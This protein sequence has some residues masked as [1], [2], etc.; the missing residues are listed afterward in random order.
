MALSNQLLSE[1]AKITN[2][3][4]KEQKNTTAYGEVI[5]VGS[6]S[7]VR[8]DGSELLTPF[9]RTVT[10][11]QGDRVRLKVE[12]HSVTVTG[13][14]SDP[15]YSSSDGE[16]N[17]GKIEEF[18]IIIS[19]KITTDEI[20]AITGYFEQIQAIIANIE[21][22]HAIYAEIE[23]LKATYA[24]IDHLN[25]EDMKVIN[26][27]I[28]KIKSEIIESGHISADDLD[29][30]RAYFNNVQ[31]YNADFVYVSA[32]V[33]KALKAELEELDV[34]HLNARY[35]QI[36]FANIGQAAINKLKANFA[37]ID[38]ANITVAAIDNLTAKMVNIDF[39]TINQATID[40]LKA[41]YAEIDFSNIGIAAI[42]KL[43]TD[44]GIIK[45]LIV[46][47]GKITG[48]LVGVTIKGDLIEGNTIKAD[49]LVVLGED[50]IYYK[51]NID[52]LDHISTTEAAK[53]VLLTEEPDDWEENYKDYYKIVNNEYVHLSD[54]NA[55]IFQTNTFYKLSST[56]QNGLD[57]TNIIAQSVTAD[58]IR[59]SDLVAFGATIGG[60]DIDTHSIHSHLKTS[61]TSNAQGLY[62]NDSGEMAVGDA[63]RFMK[64]FYDQATNTYKLEIKADSIK[65]DSGTKDLK[66]TIN[67]MKSDIQDAQSALN[68]TIKS[69]QTQYAQNQD[70]TT[71]PTSGWS[72]NTPRWQQG[73]YIW[74]KNVVTFNDDTTREDNP[75]CITGN[76]GPQGNP[77]QSGTSSY[78]YVRYSENADGTNFIPNPTST[79]SYIG[80]YTGTLST[81]PSD[82]TAYTWSKYKGEQG[83]QGNPGQQGQP[84]SNGNGINSISYFYAVTT[85][86]VAPAASS[87]TST[88]IPTMSSTNKYLWQK[89][90]IDFTDSGVPD[91]TIVALIGIYGDRGQQGNP[92]QAGT[93]VTITSKSVMYT[94][95]T[96][97]TSIPSSGWQTSVPS[98]TL[99]QF[100][101][102]RT[103]VNYSDGNSTTSYSVAHAGTNGI[104][105]DD[106]L[107]IKTIVEQYYLSTSNT[108][109]SGGS[110][111]TN[112]PQWEENKFI[113]MRM[114]IE[115][116]YD[117]TTVYQTTYT[118]P[119]LAEAL[120]TS[121]EE[122]NN[123]NNK[124]NKWIQSV[125]VYYNT[126]DGLIAPVEGWVTNYPSGMRGKNL[127]IKNIVNYSDG[128][129]SE[130]LPRCVDQFSSPT[131][132]SVTL[133]TQS[134]FPY[135]FQK[136]GDWYINTNQN[137][138]SS[139]CQS[140]FRIYSSTGYAKLKVIYE[141]D[142]EL[143]CDYLTIN[144][145]F[146]S[147]KSSG[148]VYINLSS[149]N[150]D[151]IIKYTKDGSVHTGTDTGR[152]RF[153]IAQ[154]GLNNFYNQYYLSDSG[155]SITGGN[156]VNYVPT[157]N[158][159]TK[160]L[161]K[162]ERMEWD[163]NAITYS[164]AYLINSC[165]IN[166]S[167]TLKEIE[168]SLNTTFGTT[169]NGW[170][171]AFNILTQNFNNL[172]RY[173]RFENGNIVLGEEGNAVT[174]KIENDIIGFY[175]WGQRV[176]YLSDGELQ[177]T[178]A[179]IMTQL[180]LGNFAFVPGKSG[181][182]SFKKVVN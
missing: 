14:L 60:F 65:F 89:Q 178:N 37:D 109:R 164:D 67:D 53:F 86:Q 101:W 91:K 171:M 159:K 102:S 147:G 29:A 125:D 64:Y 110:W 118:D 11:K 76:T 133:I 139:T 154:K 163:T 38:L 155:T 24:T 112:M 16:S 5:R 165:Y 113:W 4:S 168:R 114:K 17:H 33:I 13:N 94:T 85:T 152:V 43:F 87:I 174:L 136:S 134:E 83:P 167:E 82:K 127:W 104:D 166:V 68:L 108:T 146:T 98:V 119:F 95:S 92:G 117:G 100:L 103:I 107:G 7:F 73:Y 32:E 21:E 6:D 56:Y 96:S 141:Q 176:A 145:V 130:M 75:V 169:A 51:L 71:A 28:E 48:E 59:V 8:I 162:R 135:N 12:N 54:A 72:P 93:S 46:E 123:I 22:L 36:D 97:G 172:N 111:S 144:G 88:T 79:T 106:G 116:T 26:A 34:E 126:S 137:Q 180:N 69:I 129:Y 158:D 140:T 150:N 78:T 161:W 177:V 149:G 151:I 148:E 63:N 142:S 31:A 39:A 62:L 153:E 105:G 45:D 99:G 115:W 156:W 20:Y 47:Q 74:A 124:I 128:T 58:K 30:V 157:I 80:I 1:F 131:V 2:D 160:Y 181:N 90:V 41:K 77:G 55:P 42:E 179:K 27:E 18:D 122:I 35:A 173:I 57:G 52:G 19:H 121:H 50:G 120:N 9:E 61:A 3:K 40:S 81:A 25:A 44:S 23:E 175:Q 10:V 138:N 66:Q 143:Y 132:P 49:K 170:E 70:N 15:S 182:L 84:G